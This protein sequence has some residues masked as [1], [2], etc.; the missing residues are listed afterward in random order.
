MYTDCTQEETHNKAKEFVQSA[1]DGHHVCV[2]SCG[3]A[4]SG[5]IQTMVGG[6]SESAQGILPRA[7]V[8]VFS[9]VQSSGLTVV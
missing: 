6:N 9:I 3:Q 8:Q 4:G 1:I 2:F 7:L 5:R